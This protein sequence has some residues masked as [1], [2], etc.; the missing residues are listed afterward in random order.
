MPIW[1]VVPAVVLLVVG[2]ALW[3]VTRLFPSHPRGVGPGQ[4]DAQRAA[5]GPA[6][7]LVNRSAA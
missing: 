3:G 2:V 4:G 1:V 7:P 6:D 5:A